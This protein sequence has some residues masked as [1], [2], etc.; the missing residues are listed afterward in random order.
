MRRT[1]ELTGRLPE[2]DLPPEVQAE[3]MQVFHPGEIGHG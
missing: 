2:E 3:L 1:I